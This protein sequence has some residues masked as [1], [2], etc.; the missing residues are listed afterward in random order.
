[1]QEYF[2]AYPDLPKHGIPPYCR[3]H[4]GR[5]MRAGQF[6]AAVQISANRIAWRANELAEWV[7]SRP[8]ARAVVA[9]G[10]APQGRG[11][12]VGTRVINGQV[13]NPRSRE[14]WAR[15]AEERAA[16]AE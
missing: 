10:V 9:P 4:L 12:A 2:V 13:V 1:V 7:A 8:V 3:V 16:A 11:R 5:M 6:P 14:Y 15:L